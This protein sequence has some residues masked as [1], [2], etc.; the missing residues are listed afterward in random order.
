MTITD[1]DGED[2]AITFGMLRGEED[3]EVEDDDE[4]ADLERARLLYSTLRETVEEIEA[5]GAEVKGVV[6]GLVDFYS[7]KD[8]RQE[9]LLCWK[10]GEARLSHY[11][12]LEVGFDG[13][14]AVDGHKFLSKRQELETHTEHHA[15]EV[16]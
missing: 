3:L 4:L 6:D 14:R 13:R 7:W 8:G 5:T 12:D 10:L 1:L 15:S 9:V 11:H 16:S 2:G